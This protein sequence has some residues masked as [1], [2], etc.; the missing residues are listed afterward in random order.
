M[1]NTI[2][3]VV[4]DMA[5]TTINEDNIVYKTL[6]KAV[7]A[8]GIEVD[9]STVLKICAGKEKH[10]A[11]IDLLK[12]LGIE[13]VDS[14]VV[15]ENFKKNLEEAY[16]LYEI[17]PIDGVEAFFEELK[18]RGVIVVLNT[19]YD[20]KTANKLLSKLNW[21]VG[22]QIDA[23]ITAD[24]VVTG[25]P[26]AEMINLAMEIFSISNSKNVLKAGDSAIDIEEGKSANCGLT[27]GVLS[28][29][30]SKEELAK[31]SPNY[32]FQNVTQII[33]LFV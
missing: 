4:L 13:N 10:K 28:G 14:K 30:Q 33:K 1:S 32:I 6:H 21:S 5:G 23:L 2:K 31:A 3:M 25:R 26:S 17:K 7:E 8:Q 12:N 16:D 20:S 9:L 22:N 19:G 27:V 11:I 29:A 15:F 24:D 18:N